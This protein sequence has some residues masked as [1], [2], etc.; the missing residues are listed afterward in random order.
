MTAWKQ[1]REEESSQE[2][3]R[4][5]ARQLSF[6][7]QRQRGRGGLTVVQRLERGI[8]ALTTYAVLQCHLLVSSHDETVHIIHS[9]RFDILRRFSYFSFL[10]FKKSI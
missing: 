5:Y 3:A 9:P 2:A 10:P 8:T 6:N 7:F 1:T 4:P